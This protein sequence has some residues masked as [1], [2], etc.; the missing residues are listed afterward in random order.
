MS[1]D[2]N[3]LLR[4]I[5]N[6]ISAHQL[7]V[8]K[9]ISQNRPNSIAVADAV[10]LECAWILSGSYYQFDRSLVAASIQSVLE[11][12]QLKCNRVMFGLALQ[13]YLEYP[14][15]SLVDACLVTYAELDNELPLM[16]FDK[17]LVKALPKMAQ[18]LT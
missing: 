16:S 10:L 17:K 18:L 5:L 11:I 12:P 9:L 8:L 15:I 4:L 2:T 3:A 7:S 13:R 6:D 1:L 14:T